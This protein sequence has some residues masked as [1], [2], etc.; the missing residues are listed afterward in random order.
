MLVGCGLMSLLPPGALA[1]PP[2]PHLTGVSHIA[3]FVHDVQKSRAFYK[4][5]LGFDEPFFLTNKDGSLHV[6]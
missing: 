3:L 2:R 1:Q 4:D 5:F 6:T